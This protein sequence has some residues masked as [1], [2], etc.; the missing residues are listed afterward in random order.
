[1][2]ACVHV[3]MYVCRCF[4]AV[5]ERSAV[6]A[7]TVALQ[8]PCLCVFDHSCAVGWAA[9]LRCYMLVDVAWRCCDVLTRSRLRT[10][11]AGLGSPQM[12]LR[13]GLL[14]INSLVCQ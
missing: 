3:C 12:R 10:R 7:A 2:Y 11:P 5:R 1:M 13:Q 4:V 9:L 8:L 14:V 6:V